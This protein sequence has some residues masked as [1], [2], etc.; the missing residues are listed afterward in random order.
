MRRFWVDGR[1]SQAAR[2]GRL[3][4]QRPQRAEG[5]GEEEEEEEEADEDGGGCNSRVVPGR[6][7]GD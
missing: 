2:M 5:G 3:A 6:R 1:A 4:A 7:H